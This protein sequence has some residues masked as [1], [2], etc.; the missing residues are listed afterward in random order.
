MDLFF[1]SGII[2]ES[3]N[4]TKKALNILA[5]YEQFKSLGDS[6]KSYYFIPILDFIFQHPIFT[7]KQLIEEINASKQT[8][9]TLLNKMVDQ[10]ILISSDKAK[11]R[12][13]ICPKLLSIIDS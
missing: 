3:H 9:F 1:L 5:L 8:V 12:T 13:F 6:I 2:A 10:D 7:S 11:N 4:N